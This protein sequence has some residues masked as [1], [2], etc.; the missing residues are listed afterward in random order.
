[1]YAG[2]DALTGK[3]RCDRETVSTYQTAEVALTRPQARVDQDLQPKSDLT[4]RQ[5]IGT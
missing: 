5:A 4:I 1:V 3:E 2:T